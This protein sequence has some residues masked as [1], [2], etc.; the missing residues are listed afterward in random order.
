MV[1]LYLSLRIIPFFLLITE[2]PAQGIFFSKPHDS[3]A[4]YLDSIEW[5]WRCKWLQ[6][7]EGVREPPALSR[8]GL[9]GLKMLIHNT[10]SFYAVPLK[11]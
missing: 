8:G 9:K 1:H 4:G 10:P 11:N 7:A 3:C 5:F 2:N 6:M